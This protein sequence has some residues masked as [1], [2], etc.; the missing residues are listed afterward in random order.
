MAQDGRGPIAVLRSGS[1]FRR[2]PPPMPDPGQRVRLRKGRRSLDGSFR[3]IFEPTTAHTGEV[4]IWVTGE[5]EFD[6]ST[7]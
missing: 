2:K 5:E 1:L 4:A 3:A 7:Y 6:A